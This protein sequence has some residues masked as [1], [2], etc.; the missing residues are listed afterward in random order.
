MEIRKQNNRIIGIVEDNETD[1]LDA[2]K[3]ELALNIMAQ[4]DF[5]DFNFVDY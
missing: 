5:V 2:F 4:S 1:L 3:H